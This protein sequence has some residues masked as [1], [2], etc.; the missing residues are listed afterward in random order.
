MKSFCE[1]CEIMVIPIIDLKFLQECSNC[2]ILNVFI[3]ITWLLVI[4]RVAI[5]VIVLDGGMW[6]VKGS[7]GHTGGWV[8]RRRD[9]VRGAR[10][11]AHRPSHCIR[12][13]P[14]KHIR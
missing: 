6:G 10:W 2:G 12:I 4:F 3:I 11:D 8:R 14:W 9:L 7:V 5:V 13:P 1:M